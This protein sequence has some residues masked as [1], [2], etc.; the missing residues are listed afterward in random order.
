MNNIDITGRKFL[1][2]PEVEAADKD[3]R[4]MRERIA[5]D[6]EVMGKLIADRD[7]WQ[8]ECEAGRKTIAE[9]EAALARTM[10]AV[11]DLAQGHTDL[12]D[13]LLACR[14]AEGLPASLAQ[15]ID[16]LLSTAVVVKQG[17]TAQSLVCEP[18]M[19]GDSPSPFDV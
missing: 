12:L 8:R 19:P 5:Q 16:G 14:G 15:Q 17:P 9:T 6:W 10:D 2:T 4:A 13:L 3:M 1:T 11:E 18:L 7:N